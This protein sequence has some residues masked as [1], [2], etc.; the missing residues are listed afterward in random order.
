MLS[1]DPVQPR[2]TLTIK[3]R[4]EPQ[5]TA[6]PGYARFVYV[7]SQPPE[8]VKQFLWAENFPDFKILE[9]KSPY[10]FVHTIF[11][12]ATP[13]ERRPES[14]SQNQWV[15]ETTIQPDAEVGPLRDF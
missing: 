9:V 2:I 13:E 1:N 7:Q 11:R 8:T 3:A 4:V 15:I 14:P 6:F 5:I 12:P 10:K